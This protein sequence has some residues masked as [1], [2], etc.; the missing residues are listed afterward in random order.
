MK[1]R[2]KAIM[3][4]A[5]LLGVF[6]LF[7]TPMVWKWM[8]PIKYRTEVSAAAE[9]FQVDPFLVLAII[10]TESDFELDKVSKKGAV[11]LMQ[12]MPDTATW[13]ADQ[14]GFA[15]VSREALAS[16]EI[17]I[18]LGTWYLSFLL[19]MFEGNRVMAIA[20]YNA[21]P[22]KVN[23]WIANQQWDGTLD[24]LQHIPYGETRHYV[25]RVLYF[26]DRY[27]KIYPP[28]LQE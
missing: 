11:G 12:I 9:R 8:Y 3:L 6:I 26:Y 14:A 24:N 17:N 27:Q 2:K 18:Q 15:G 25:Q 19:D 21:G 22:G 5:I 13:I 1:R 4:L 7:N 28:N 10:R 20:A 16:P 23:S